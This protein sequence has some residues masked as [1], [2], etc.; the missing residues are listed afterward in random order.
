MNNINK[1]LCSIATTICVG[2]YAYINVSSTNKNQYQYHHNNHHHHRNHL[3]S[4]CDNKTSDNSYNDRSLHRNFIADAA[5]IVSPAVVN[6]LCAV[7]SNNNIFGVT[8][9]SSG[10][11]FIIS[12]DGFIV[13]NAHVIDKTSSNKV[14]V[15]MWNSKK[16]YGVI[17]SFDRTSD[18]ALIKL[19]DVES[20]EDLPIA[21]LGINNRPRVGEF[22]VALGSPLHLAN[23]VT[24]GII[25]STARHAS[26]LGMV[27]N[28]NEFIQTDAAINEGILLL[29]TFVTFIFLIIIIR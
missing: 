27:K 25:S 28:R 6:I 22:V 11:G 3:L 12:K 19:I 18:I 13:T 15:T 24:F 1:K 29:I 2:T 7:D 14:L 17:H 23:S 5:E 4:Y 20:D 8:G 21:K 16:R 10:S 9:A 26:E